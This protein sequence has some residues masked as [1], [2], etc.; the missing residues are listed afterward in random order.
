MLSKKPKAATADLHKALLGTRNPGLGYMAKRAQPVLY[1]ADTLLHPTHHPELSR[2][3]AYWLPAN[4]RASQT[5]NPNSPVTP[6]GVKPTSGASKTVPKRAPRNHSSLPVVQIVLWYL[7]SGCSRHMTGDRARL[8]NFVDKFIGQFCDG[9]LEVAFRQHSCHI[10]NYDMDDLLQ[11]NGTEFVN[12]TLDGWFESVG[13]SHE[14]SVPR[15]PQ[16]NGVVERR[17]RTLMEAARTMLIFAKAPLFLWAEAVAT[18]CYTLN[19]SLVHTLHGKTYYEL[20]KGKKPNLQYFRVFGSLCYPTNDYDDVG[21]LKAKADIDDLFQWFDD[22]EVIPP[23]VV[24]IPPVN[25]QAAPA[26]ENA[27]G[28]PS[29]TVLSEGAPAVTKSL[30]PHQIPLPDTSDPDVETLFDNV[31]SNVFETYT[32]PETDS[33]ASSSNTVNID[34]LF[35]CVHVTRLSLLKCTLLL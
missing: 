14:T 31:D 10:R 24:P 35:V 20:L 16:Q 2:E 33:E 18:A 27:N 12:K 6:F 30:L 11:D 22:D 34:L 26:P 19:R 23:L 32:A 29:T 7:D 21:K 25:V 1:D 8:I 5:S 3:Q 13:I 17:N 15:S 9:G 28:L 4:E